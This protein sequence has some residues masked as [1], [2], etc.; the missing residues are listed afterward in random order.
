MRR[1]LIS[2]IAGLAAVLSTSTLPSLLYAEQKEALDCRTR[3]EHEEC[4]VPFIAN[5]LFET[6]DKGPYVPKKELPPINMSPLKAIQESPSII[7]PILFESGKANILPEYY[8]QINKV[9][10]ILKQR[11]DK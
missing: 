6:T 7:L 2:A 3:S 5:E 9:G 11:S 4:S 10:E 8:T 1:Y